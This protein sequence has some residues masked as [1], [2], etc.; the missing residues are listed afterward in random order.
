MALIHGQNVKTT[1]YTTAASNEL[2]IIAVYK[3]TQK[4]PKIA[5]NRDSRRPGINFKIVDL[6]YINSLSL[7]LLLLLIF[8]ECTWN[9][10]RDVKD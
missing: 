5:T 4:F 1:K 6:N 2:A 9:V 8:V 3:K 10:K 7:T